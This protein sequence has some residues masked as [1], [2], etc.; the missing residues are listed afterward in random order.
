MPSQS[1][2][3]SKTA[4]GA[5]LEYSSIA[6]LTEMG[7]YVAKSI[8]PCCPYDLVAVNPETGAVY[9]VDVKSK[10]YRKN[11][12]PGWTD[13]SVRINRVLSK[14]QKEFVQKTGLNIELFIR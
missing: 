10:T 14:R 11:C 13:K 1:K 4:K 12:P 6:E 9:L 7:L 3:I 8:D 5:A 2:G